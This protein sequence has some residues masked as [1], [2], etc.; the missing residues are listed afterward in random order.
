MMSD[1]ATRDRAQ[2]R[3]MMR[4]MTRDRAHHRAFE[5]SGLRGRNYSQDEH[6]GAHYGGISFHS[7]VS[8]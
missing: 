1:G 7:V 2:N 6:H 4:K 5:T 8:R 3:M